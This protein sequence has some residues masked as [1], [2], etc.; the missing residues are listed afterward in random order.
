MEPELTDQRDYTLT[1]QNERGHQSATVR[2]R[3]SSPLSPMVI[4]SSALVTIFSLF[5]LSLALMCFSRTFQRF[6][7][8]NNSD[9]SNGSSGNSSPQTILSSSSRRNKELKT[10]VEHLISGNVHPASNGNSNGFTMQPGQTKGIVSGLGSG[11]A[12]NSSNLSAIH[13]AQQQTNQLDD[14]TKLNLLTSINSSESSS[15]DQRRLLSHLDHQNS[16]SSRLSSASPNS[17]RSS[18]TMLNVQGVDFNLQASA[19]NSSESVGSS[20]SSTIRKPQRSLDCEDQDG[21]ETGTHIHMEPNPSRAD[22]DHSFDRPNSNSTYQAAESVTQ[23]IAHLSPDLVRHAYDNGALI[24]ANVDYSH[25][26]GLANMIDDQHRTTPRN[27]LRQEMLETQSLSIGHGNNPLVSGQS[28]AGLVTGA[29][30]V[31][32]KV[33]ATIAMMNS[34]AAANGQQT[35]QQTGALNGALR[36]QLSH[37]RQPIMGLVRKQGPPKPPKPPLQQTNRLYQSYAANADVSYAPNRP[38]TPTPDELAAEY[39]RLNFPERAEL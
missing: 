24:Y 38:S 37:S 14:G 19:L 35:G 31:R 26:V 6:R 29:N 2:L 39:S 10:S 21:R 27:G 3:V 28:S 18:S 16:V 8:P 9:D 11:H 33:G 1:V 13:Q 7:R 12:N 4:I 36:Q 20:P 34:L 22:L 25:D 15:G 17:N 5:L 32:S 30:G 23:G